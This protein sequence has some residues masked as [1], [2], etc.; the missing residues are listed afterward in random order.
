MK[1]KSRKAKKKEAFIISLVTALIALLLLSGALA[2]VISVFFKKGSIHLPLTETV[3]Y[4][5]TVLYLITAAIAHYK[6]WKKL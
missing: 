4:V 2:Y 1:K 3:M 6:E 5:I